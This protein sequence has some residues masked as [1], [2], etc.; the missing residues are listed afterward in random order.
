MKL[1]LIK[2][3]ITYFN[4]SAAYSPYEPLGLMYIASYLRKYCEG[5]EVK[6]LDAS[7]GTDQ[8]QWEGSFYKYGLTDKMLSDQIK[9][10]MPDIVGISSMFTI[11]AKG[12]H[13]TA[14][15]VKQIN[16]RIP[17]I[18]GGAHASAFP[19]WV[20]RDN[21]ID[22]VVKGE[23]EETLAEIINHIKNKTSFYE[24]YGLIYKKDG[25]IIENPPRPFIKNLDSIPHPARDLVDMDIYFHERFNY[26]HS[27]SPPRA[28][29]VS[30]RGCPYKCI[31][32]S[33]H[34]LWRHSYRMRTPEDVVDEIEYLVRTYGAREIAFL[35][36]NLSVS[37]KR[38]LDICDEII[39]RKLNI[40][41]CTPNG[42]A[43]WTL[44]K[45]V[46][47]R[48]KESG[49][50]KLTFGIETGSL[51]TQK[52]IRKS[53]IDLEKS[54]ALIKYCDKV[55]IWTHSTFIIGFPY[56]TEKDILDTI[57]YA[58]DCGLDMSTFFIATPYPGTEMYD[59]YR[60]EGLLPELVDTK[61]LEWLG[62]LGH[63][64]CDTTNFT[65]QQI[66]EYI[67]T[68]QR[69]VYINKAVSFLNPLR[70][71]PKIIGKDEF[72]YFARQLA[73]YSMR[74]YKSFFKC[75]MVKSE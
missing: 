32:C 69:K 42:I 39:S 36:D 64:M 40:K 29:V 73:S 18:I 3:P 19:D 65:R 57:H 47:S 70:L 41:W 4:T 24:T 2:P 66:E 59:I 37:K 7:A 68:A 52:F 43:I 16:K 38:M 46:I 14:Q 34:S 25:K 5:T 21:N 54:K 13:D 28:T 33:I 20:L 48:M 30:S 53:H 56:E 72:N 8:Q 51:S 1:L 74:F 6:I 23:G 61:S 9:A 35:D 67:S 27:M 10:F 12:A 31:F 26:T 75:K 50:Y 15:A 71:L 60:Q 17:V 22:A 44:D 55:G 62:S 58:L 11:N 45:E 63:S 49:C